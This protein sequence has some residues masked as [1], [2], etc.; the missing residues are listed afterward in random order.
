M[1]D[2]DYKR[3]IEL[4]LPSA[5]R[6]LR[7]RA[8][9]C[10]LVAP[11]QFLDSQFVLFRTQIETELKITSQVCKLEY[12]LNENFDPDSRGIQVC[13]AEQQEQVFIYTAQENNPIYLPVFLSAT[14]GSFVVKVPGRLSPY[15]RQII[16]FVNKYKLVGTQ[17]TFRYSSSIIKNPNGDNPT[18][19]KTTFP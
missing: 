4:L 8:W 19:G 3:L 1:F 7:M 15:A 6:K 13:D 14:G 11:I 16:A 2:I 18:L 10:S 5:L 12:Y 17:W 9:L